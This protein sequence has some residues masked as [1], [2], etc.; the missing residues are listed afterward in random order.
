MRQAEAQVR[1]ASIMIAQQ[2]RAPWDGKCQAEM[3][4][5]ERNEEQAMQFLSLTSV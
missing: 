1:S 2:R 4:E 3:R 5:R